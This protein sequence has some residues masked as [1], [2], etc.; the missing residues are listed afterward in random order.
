MKN[1]ELENLKQFFKVVGLSG[2]RTIKE[3]SLDFTETNI[4]VCSHS[5]D[6][7]IL[8]K[9]VFNSNPIGIIEKIGLVRFDNFLKYINIINEPEIL[10]EDNRIIVKGERKKG[11]FLIQ[12]SEFI[13]TNF[14][15]VK[16]EKHDSGLR[17]GISVEIDIEK[18]KVI[19]KY[20]QL[21]NLK[22]DDA[23]FKIRISKGELK[24]VVG[25]KNS[26]I[27]EEIIGVDYNGGKEVITVNLKQPFLD[28]ID[29]LNG[30]VK[31][32]VKKEAPV[33]IYMENDF[34][35]V[36]ILIAQAY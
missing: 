1:K 5:N 9:A 29:G 7:T 14:D 6:N 26:D 28:A 16:F 36:R 22:K 17:E 18:L 4:S 31:L 2:D 20:I 19:K 11:S 10:L 13:Q 21:S 23:D 33:G 25:T 15:E 27:Y 30:I 34:T 3:I 8:V 35:N 24:I 12:N 32:S